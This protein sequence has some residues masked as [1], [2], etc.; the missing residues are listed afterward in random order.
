MTSTPGTAISGSYSHGKHHV[1]A[2]YGDKKKKQKTKD[3]SV[4]RQVRV[5]KI[6]VSCCYLP[7]TEVCNILHGFAFETLV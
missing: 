7:V 6:F 4:V 3:N 1:S 5:G 2:G